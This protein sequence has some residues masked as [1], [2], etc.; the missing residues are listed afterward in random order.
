LT[1]VK[2]IQRIPAPIVS[3]KPTPPKPQ[4]FNLFDMMAQVE[5]PTA[6]EPTELNVDKETSEILPPKATEKKEVSL[7]A[8]P[9]YQKYMRFQ[10]QYPQSV[11]A[12]KVGDFF[13]IF[14]E[15]AVKISNTF[16]LTLTGRDCGI[17]ERVPMIGFPYHASDMYL[18]KISERFDLVV[19]EDN[20]ATPYEITDKEENE[21][22]MYE[23]NDNFDEDLQ[24][25]RSSAKAFEQAA[26]CKLLEIFGN[27]IMIPEE[28]Y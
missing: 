22:T 18:H 17:D 9:L 16:D 13:E 28:D 27:E 21:P 3:A 26:L 12:Y 7:Q 6:D 20:V 19:V 15:N 11:I 2:Y 8:S 25:M 24:E 14:G 4:Q 5:T 23:N 1:F 10:N